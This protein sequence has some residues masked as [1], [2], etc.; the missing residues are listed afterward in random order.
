[1]FC[2]VMLSQIGF[3]VFVSLLFWERLLTDFGF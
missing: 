2:M 3:V 1:M